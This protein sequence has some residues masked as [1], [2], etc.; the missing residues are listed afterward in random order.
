MYSGKNV[1]IESDEDFVHLGVGAVHSEVNE[2]QLT[3]GTGGGWQAR[4]RGP[5]EGDDPRVVERLR[6]RHLHQPSTRP[7]NLNTYIN[8]LG[9]KVKCYTVLIIW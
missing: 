9:Y 3:T 2:I 7:Y 5:L 8:K 4:L 1:H 6:T